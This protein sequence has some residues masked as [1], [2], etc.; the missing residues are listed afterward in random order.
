MDRRTIAAA[1]LLGLALPAAAA[2]GGPGFQSET[3]NEASDMAGGRASANAVYDGSA[4]RDPV[5]GEVSGALATGGLAVPTP[6]A[7][8]KARDVLRPADVPA[9]E[10]A[11]EGL[12]NSR[13]LAF[14]A[15]GAAVGG[16]IGW[17][18]GGPLGGLIGA[19]VGFAI[20][21]VLSKFLKK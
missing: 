19:A 11:H 8:A 13:S 3:Y 21:F 7:P 2:A 12:F 16:V 5:R 9:P 4:Q 10:T 15:G 1:L 6:P 17:L 18:V 14:G 20:G